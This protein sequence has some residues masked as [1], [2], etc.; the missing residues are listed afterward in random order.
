MRSTEQIDYGEPGDVVVSSEVADSGPPGAGQVRVRVEAC[1]INPSDLL[2]L[3]GAYGTTPEPLPTGAGSQGV[4]R[5][6]EVGA[7]VEHLRPGDLVALHRYFAGCGIWREELNHPATRLSALPEGNLLQMA[8]LSGNPPSAWLMLHD[9]RALG[10]G[11]WII[12]NAA[13]SSVGHYITKLASLLGL[14]VINVVRRESAVESLRRGAGAHVFVSS[15]ALAD[16]VAEVTQGSLPMLAIDAVA[17]VDTG[18]LA[19]CVAESG[20]LVNYGLL[21]GE[22]CRIDP[23]HLVFRDITCRGF[24]LQRWWDE[25]DA[26]RIASVHHRLA[27]MI[28]DGA[29]AVPVAASYPFSRVREALIAAEQPGRDGKVFLTPD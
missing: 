12:Q 28:A 16:Q 11:D 22:P 13:N 4:G 8:M 19:A 1:P 24:W 17:G 23:R 27:G 26:E 20:T 2:R 18:R 6:V 10:P 15:D 21:S 29:L 3:R 5:V 9:Y 14:G 7:G 25:A